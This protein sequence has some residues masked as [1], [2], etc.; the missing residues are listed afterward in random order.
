MAYIPPFCASPCTMVRINGLVR[1][2]F[3]KVCSTLGKWA[4]LEA[5]GGNDFARRAC[6]TA[7]A[8]ASSG[9]L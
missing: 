5:D 3:R 8:G 4:I 2:V 1:T 6:E 9:R 7:D